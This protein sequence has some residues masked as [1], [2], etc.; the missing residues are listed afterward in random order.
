MARLNFIAL[1]DLHNSANDLLHSPVIQQALVHQRQEKWVNEVSEASLRMLDVCG[2]TKDVLLLVKQHLQ[3]L[4][5]TLRRV[6]IGES[7]IST[8]IATYNRYRKKLKKETLKCLHSLRGIKSKSNIVT[9][10]HILSPAV[11]PNLVIVVD[12]L[13]E[14]KVTTISI[15][16]SLL[17]L[18]SIPW[19]DQKSAKGSFTSMFMRSGSQQ[20]LYDICDEMALQSANKRMEAVETAIEILE[21]EIEC[22]FRRLIQTRVSLLNILTN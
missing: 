5:S 21:V 17:S 7:D 15:V 10:D 13:K 2:I 12:V 18:I 20:S 6:I 16:E 4:Q 9:S 19:L 3:D 14:V 1:R 11:N 22:M 8:K